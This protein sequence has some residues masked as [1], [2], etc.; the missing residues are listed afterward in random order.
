LNWSTWANGGTGSCLPALLRVNISILLIKNCSQ[1]SEH[2]TRGYHEFNFKTIWGNF[3]QISKLLKKE[4]IEKVDGILAD[5]GTSQF[6]I[7]HQAGFSFQQDSP[8]D[9]RMSQAH[10]YFKASEY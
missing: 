3:A 10:H 6:Q 8:L 5:F 1:S 4:K 7:F 2:Y 9:M